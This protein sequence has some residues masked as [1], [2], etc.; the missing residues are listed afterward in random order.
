MCDLDIDI[1]TTTLIGFTKVFCIFMGNK[2]LYYIYE[3]QG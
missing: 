3:I 1:D 2:E